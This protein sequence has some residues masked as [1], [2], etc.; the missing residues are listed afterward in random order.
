[1]RLVM[2][3]LLVLNAGS[4]LWAMA[5][6]L[7]AGGE[8]F[9]T[10]LVKAYGAP[11]PDRIGGL[12]HPKSLACLSAEQNYERYLMRAETVQAVPPEAKVSV[13][14]VAEDAQLPYRG[15]VFP[16]RPSH[17]VRME[18]GRKPSPDGRSATTQIAEKYIARDGDRWYLIMP[19]STP[20]GLRRLREMGL[21]H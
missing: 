12:L 15:F 19:C 20:D 6:T 16:L 18:F 5:E 14:P 4:P 1:M 7:D 8:R 9:K 3:L 13:E 11:N 2:T 17:V 10:E 21:L